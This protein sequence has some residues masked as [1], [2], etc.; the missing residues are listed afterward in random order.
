MRG[1]EG[2]RVAVFVSR[3]DEEAQ[4]NGA[5][6]VAALEGSGALAHTLSAVDAKDADFY[7]G[8]S[9]ALVAVGGPTEF[10][11]DPRVVQLAREFLAADKPV[12]A[13]GSAISLIL[14]AGGAAARTIACP[15]SLKAPL[16]SAG[17]TCAKTPLHVD[18]TL[19]TA[20]DQAGAANFAAEVVRVFSSHLEER[21]VDE[22]SDLSFPA[23]DPPATTPATVGKASPEV[24]E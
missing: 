7:S 24:R 4:K 15:E 11:G 13:Y 12:A 16:E 22:M 5:M 18:D 3:D 21:A 9:A 20:S 1:L 17:G 19:I 6:V 8:A 23:S 14:A 2:R 10:K